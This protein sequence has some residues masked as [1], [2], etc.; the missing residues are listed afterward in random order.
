MRYQG[1]LHNW[2]DDKGFGFVTPNGGGDKAFVHLK[3]FERL[4]RRPVE[5]DLITYALARD[6]QGRLQANAIRYAGRPAKEDSGATPGKL[7]PIFAALF[8]IALV[9]GVFVQKIPPL[10]AVA[11][12]AMSVVALFA[13][14]QDKKAAESGEW[15]TPEASLHAIGLLC[16]WPGALLA[17]RVFRHKWLKREFQVTYWG[18]VVLNIAALLVL[19]SDRGF[20][21]FGL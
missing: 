13:Y 7:G 5:G 15:R 16:G 12:A 11:Y 21:W 17:Q 3:A 6:A 9:A 10:V 4:P 1:R 2:N 8:C 19:T 20:A 14:G 18:T